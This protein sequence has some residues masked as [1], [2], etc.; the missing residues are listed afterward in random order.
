MTKEPRNPNE[1]PKITEKLIET[2]REGLIVQQKSIEGQLEKQYSLMHNLLD[3]LA[4]SEKTLKVED[5]EAST[6]NARTKEVL[7]S[8][9]EQIKIGEDQVKQVKISVTRTTSELIALQVV[10]KDMPGRIESL[11]KLIIE[12]SKQ[13][14]ITDNPRTEKLRGEIDQ[15]LAG[16]RQEMS[17]VEEVAT[18]SNIQ[19]YDEY[20]GFKMPGLYSLLKESQED[21]DKLTA[22]SQKSGESAA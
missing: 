11:Q 13:Q 14:K 18:N 8:L 15:I 4:R 3:D 7:R 16:S 20:I 22:A 5:Q 19:G 10:K 6:D 1:P 12:L 21:Y 2:K 17:R 9:Q